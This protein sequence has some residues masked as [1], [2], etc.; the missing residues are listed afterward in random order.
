M[1]GLY[2][3]DVHD[4]EILRASINERVRVFLFGESYLP[5]INGSTV[6]LN[7]IRYRSLLT[8]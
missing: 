4:P 3:I 5:R 6:W 8:V 1:L 7:Q 2:K